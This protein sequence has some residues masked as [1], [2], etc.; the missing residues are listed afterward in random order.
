MKLIICV[1]VEGCGV[2]YWMNP[3]IFQMASPDELFT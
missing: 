2:G 1:P 3:L